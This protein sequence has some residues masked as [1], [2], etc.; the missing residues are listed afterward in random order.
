MPD[1]HACPAGTGS[2]RLGTR[3]LLWHRRA[4]GMGLLLAAAV[5]A[6]AVAAIGLGSDRLSFGDTLA[7]QLGQGTRLQE[8]MLFRIRLP[9]VAAAIVAGLAMGM[10][11][12]L[13][14][15]LVRN[16]LATPDM[17][18]VNEGASLG[19]VVFALYL[20]VG[21]WPW[22]AAPFGALL[23]AAALFALCRRPGEQ[24]YLFIVI[25]IAVSELLGA[26]G[27]FALSTQPIVHLGSLYLWSMGHFA[28]IG[29]PTVGPV[30]LLLLALCPAM[31]LVARPLATL[32]FGEATA[33]NLGVA[34]P[35]V[36]LGVL[37]LAILV[38]AL[39]TAIGGPVVFIAMAAPIMAHWLARDHLAPIWLSALCGALLLLGSDTL[40]RLLAQPEEIP[41]GVM[42]RLLGGLLLLA[43]LIKD[44][45][46]SD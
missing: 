44:R 13:I 10:A 33:R 31:A 4:S 21:S 41:T 40:V 45:R 12:C 15:T 35:W 19:V 37:A 9:R 32:R 23:A 22:W 24:G 2:L 5:L 17:V 14:Q 26:L 20:T 25:G 29:Y 11:G 46:G 18:G 3:T 27:D 16:H 43:L 39:G 1:L 7:T 36:Q 8:I 28:G 30:A 38:A 6:L 42:T 34:V